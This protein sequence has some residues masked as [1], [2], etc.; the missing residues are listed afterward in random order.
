MSKAIKEMVA[1]DLRERLGKNRDILV[2]DNSKLDGVTANNLR[3][4]LRKSNIRMW[5]TL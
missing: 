2:V 1:A 3:L 5:S 4:K